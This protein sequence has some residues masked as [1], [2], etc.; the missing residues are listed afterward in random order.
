M[1][2]PTESTTSA[3]KHKHLTTSLV[4]HV[5]SVEKTETPGGGQGQDWYRY[6][7]TNHRSTIQGF[8]RGSRQH[9]CDYAAQYAEQLNLRT[10]NGPSTWSPRGNKLA[11]RPR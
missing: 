9:V 1:T 5:D 6:V 11:S 4:F 7:L 10:V 3:D 8:R 2:Q